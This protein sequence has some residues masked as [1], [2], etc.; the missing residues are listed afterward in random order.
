MKKMSQR[1]AASSPAAHNAAESPKAELF[2]EQDAL[3]GTCFCPRLAPSGRHAKARQPSIKSAECRVAPLSI[4]ASFW[5]NP[6]C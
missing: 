4:F 2:S 1:A 3:G 6:T 5:S